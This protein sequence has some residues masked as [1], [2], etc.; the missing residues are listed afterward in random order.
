[1]IR[2][3][4]SSQSG[5]SASI[6]SEKATPPN[7]SAVSSRATSQAV[8]KRSWLAGSYQTFVDVPRS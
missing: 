3:V 8:A 2:P 6:P 4:R 5:T 7:V 1:M